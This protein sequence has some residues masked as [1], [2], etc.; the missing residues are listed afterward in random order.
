MDYYVN[1][2]MA[3]PNSVADVRMILMCLMKGNA[4]GNGILHVVR[5]A[6]AFLILEIIEIIIANSNIP[7]ILVVD[8]TNL[9]ALS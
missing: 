4:K 9:S 8:V 6:I 3:I 2:K 7:Q 5:T 1:K